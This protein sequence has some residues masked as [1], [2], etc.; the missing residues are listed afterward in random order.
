MEEKSGH[1]N[2]ISLRLVITMV[3]LRFW[4][5]GIFTYTGIQKIIHIVKFKDIIANYEILPYWM[6]NITAIILPWLEIW[7]GIL[8]IA[9]IFVRACTIIQISLLLIFTAT[10]SINIAR[11]LDFSCGC[12]SEANTASGMNY[13]HIIFNMSLVVMASLL[14]FLER[15]RFSHNRTKLGAQ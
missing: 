1:H 2:T 4:M 5:G 6:I 15:R 3:I 9:G 13:Q 7:V 8:I 10:I 11:G 12:F 14:Y